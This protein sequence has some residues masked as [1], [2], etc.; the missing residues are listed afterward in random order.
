MKESTEDKRLPKDI[1]IPQGKLT[2]KRGRGKVKKEES[3]KDK[4]EI[5]Y[6]D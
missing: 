2:D 1:S 3:E 4:K 6:V 5:E